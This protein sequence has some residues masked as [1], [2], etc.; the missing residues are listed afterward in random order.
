MSSSTGERG[1]SGRGRALALWPELIVLITAVCAFLPTLDGSG[2]IP[3]DTEF[4]NYPLLRSVATLLS[5]GHL[6]SWDAFTY[7]GTPLLANAQA[8]WLY[9]PHLIL[10]GVL[11]LLGQPLTERA[12]DVL[13]VAHLVLAGLATAA[14]VRGRRLGGAAAAYA[15]AFVVLSGAAVSQVQHFGMVETFAWLPVGVL[16]V[17]RLAQGVTAARVVA[18]GATV[19]LMIT[20]GFLPMIPACA[21]VLL[22]VA[23]ARLRGVRASLTGAVAGVVLGM[24]FAAAMLLPIVALLGA[25]PPLELHGSLPVAG[26]ITAVI[27]DAFGHWAS[28]AAAYSGPGGVTSSYYFLGGAALIV[29]PLA[30][31]SGRRALL[32]AALLVMLLLASFGA[33]G[34]DIASVVQGLPSVGPLWRPEDVA[35]AASVPLALLLARGLARA[36]TPAQLATAALML[37]VLV[38]IPFS[39]HGRIE[40]ALTQA[41]WQMIVAVGLSAAALVGAFVL[42]EQRRPGVAVALALAAVVGCAELAADAST[43]Y[44]VNSRSPTT[45]AGP[46]NSGDGS[47]VLARLRELLAP[48]ER[49]A[50][51]VANGNPAWAGFPPIWR[52]PDVNG[53]Q[54][55][56]SKYQLARVVS[57]GADFGGRSRIFPVVPAVRAFLEE[58][59][60][61]YVAVTAMLDPFAHRA[62]YEPVFR[63]ALYHVYRVQGTFSRAYAVDASCLDRSGENAVLGCRTGTPVQATVRN[64]TVQRMKIARASMPTTVITGEPWYPGWHASSPSG[65]VAVRRAGYLAAVT[66]APG[67]TTVSLGYT[68]PGLLVGAIISALALGGSLMLLLL[69]RRRRRDPAEPRAPDPATAPAQ[70]YEYSS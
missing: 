12:V 41:P 10:D 50:M 35:L 4:F 20:A 66:V 52:L 7:G 6:P 42:H 59:D 23:V 65:S 45:S 54:P 18:L 70:R 46:N 51:D 24:A 11:S 17:D 31:T 29:L 53:F 3:Y 60:T 22:G 63:D 2:H 34:G 38:A 37:A 62:G 26:L 28:T 36:P 15:G 19:A 14:V 16:A 32:E 49:V 21:A 69:R 44:F 39:G 30:L 5:A 56:F 67:V 68:P 57:T 9:P 40:H 55:Q 64:G 25:L 27:P 48:G 33:I 58:M 47:A 13:E 43:R 1:R 61:R 8:G